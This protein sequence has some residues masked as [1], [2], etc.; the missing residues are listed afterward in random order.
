MSRADLKPRA[1]L[2]FARAD[3]HF[4]SMQIL[5]FCVVV[6]KEGDIYIS[7]LNKVVYICAMSFNHPYR[8]S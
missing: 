4:S 2:I 3:C 1:D 6:P 5:L 7:L 8:I